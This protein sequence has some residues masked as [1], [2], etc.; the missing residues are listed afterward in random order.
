MGPMLLRFIPAWIALLAAACA[1]AQG[2]PEPMQ[3]G[4]AQTGNPAKSAHPGLRARAAMAARLL[5]AFPESRALKVQS[6][7]IQVVLGWRL[8]ND[9]NL[10][11]SVKYRAALT[12][13]RSALKA[14]PDQ[15]EAK[16]HID[17]IEGIYQSMGRPVP[18]SSG[19]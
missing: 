8:M 16:S 2:S 13:F 1:L 19:R 14:V 15:K 5:A 11:A 17:L 3:P 10:P 9:P 12:E 4:R 18:D 6:A 7:Q